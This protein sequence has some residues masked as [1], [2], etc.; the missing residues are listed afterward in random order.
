MNVAVNDL[1]D[2]KEG[3]LLVHLVRFCPAML[4]K[5][6]SVPFETV[7]VIRLL[8][9]LESFTGSL[10]FTPNSP[11]GGRL[12]VCLSWFRSES[13]LHLLFPDIP[14]SVSLVVLI[15]VAGPAVLGLV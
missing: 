12:S 14:S 5:M 2:F 8:S 6:T 3:S 11:K 1:V 13:E 10:T 9:F 4:F 15:V 7:S